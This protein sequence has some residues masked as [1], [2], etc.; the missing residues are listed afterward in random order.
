MSTEPAGIAVVTGAASGIGR[1]IAIRLAEDGYNLGL[2]DLKNSEAALASVQETVVQNTGRRVV[3]YLGDVALD[4][5]VKGFIEFVVQELGG[6]DV[7]GLI[8][9]LAVSS[10]FMCFLWGFIASTDDRECWNCRLQDYRGR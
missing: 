2:F 9:C 5:D 6:L 3:I 4:T 7:V 10:I 1:S 8:G